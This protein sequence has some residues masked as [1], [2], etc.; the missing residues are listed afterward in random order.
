MQEFLAF[1]LDGLHEETG[2]KVLFPVESH[3]SHLMPE[4]F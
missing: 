2:F 4:L 1:C 3:F